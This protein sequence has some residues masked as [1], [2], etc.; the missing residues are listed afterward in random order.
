MPTQPQ[1]L[2]SLLILLGLTSS[3]ALLVPAFSRAL[4]SKSRGGAIL[5]S[6]F[7][8]LTMDQ[9]VAM[10]RV[11]QCLP[12][13][14]EDELGAFAAKAADPKS[15]WADPTEG[16]WAEIKAAY[17]DLAECSDE[18]LAA[19]RLECLDKQSPM[20]TPDAGAG[21]TTGVVPIAFLAATIVFGFISAGGDV[22]CGGDPASAP[23]LARSCAEYN[24]R[25]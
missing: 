21:I 8:S 25:K 20:P 10:T 19:A 23:A 22:V 5:A 15:E 13:R 12:A 11:A 1:M 14:E 4:P 6:A 2:T 18:T 24:A 7:D 16:T 3:H 9:K 17:P